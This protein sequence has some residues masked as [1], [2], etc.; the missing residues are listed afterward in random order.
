MVKLD[1]NGAGDQIPSEADLGTVLGLL[2]W[3]YNGDSLVA[4]DSCR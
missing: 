2:V 4:A 3:F 1:E